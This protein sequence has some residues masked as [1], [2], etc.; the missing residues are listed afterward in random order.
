[1]DPDMGP[2]MIRAR[3]PSGALS[4][5][6]VVTLEASPY[7]VRHLLNLA[8]AGDLGTTRG[9][10]RRLMAAWFTAAE[11]QSPGKASTSTPS[12]APQWRMQR[13]ERR[14]S[15]QVVDPMA[16][17]RPLDFRLSGCGY[18][19][20]ARYRRH[21]WANAD[22]VA[23]ALAA[24]NSSVETAGQTPVLNRCTGCVD[25]LVFAGHVSAGIE[26]RQFNLSLS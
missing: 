1:M 13:N 18:P 4:L 9:V 11:A 17:T 12:G 15:F 22:R 16:S 10:D 21:L 14:Q 7:R 2:D 3:D 26:P 20:T 25:S 6:S 24:S 19:W 5:W 8:T 23:A